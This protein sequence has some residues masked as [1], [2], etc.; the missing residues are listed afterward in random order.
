MDLAEID[1]KI[2]LLTNKLK[3]LEWQREQLLVVAAN[4]EMEEEI[5]RMIYEVK[6]GKVKLKVLPPDWEDAVGSDYFE[7]NHTDLELVQFGLEFEECE[8][9]YNYDS[10][11]STRGSD[12][13]ALG[14]GKVI[15]MADGPISRDDIIKQSY[16][17]LETSSGGLKEGIEY[18]EDD[19]SIYTWSSTEDR[20]G[21]VN[22][23]INNMTLIRR[24]D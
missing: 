17:H 23:T 24:R 9:R 14:C 10:D 11:G 6:S 4:E 13:Y 1:A 8:F 20:A 22:I 21:T 18:E 19:E 7:D 5:H 12:I 3:K 15:K 16:E 2:E